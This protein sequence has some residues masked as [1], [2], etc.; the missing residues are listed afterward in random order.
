[1]K[2][3]EF[4]TP[5]NASK[6]YADTSILIN[7]FTSHPPTHE[8]V[9]KAIARMNYIHSGY[10]KSGKIL[11]DD[12]L[13]TLSVFMTEPV[14]WVSRYEWRDF[15]AMEVC[16]IGTF[17]KSIG[18][19]MEID[20]SKLAGFERGWRDGLEFYHDIKAWAGDYEREKMVPARCSRRTADE[21]MALLLA[22]VPK[23]LLAPA[24]KVV[25]VLMGER[26]R[27][28]ML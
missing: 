25:T 8:R 14:A 22:L 15:S 19:A 13:Y 21:T 20:Y 3:K 2:T 24:T 1:M 10:Q 27:K 26:L 9:I 11:Q 18:D 4:S 17:W 12:L 6:R 23:K 7:E 28:A 5:E 16:A